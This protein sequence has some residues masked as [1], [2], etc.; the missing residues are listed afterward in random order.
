MAN[1]RATVRALLRP[2]I[3]F[4]LLFIAM[5]LVIA[6]APSAAQDQ[7]NDP[8]GDPQPAAPKWT[9]VEELLASGDPAG[10]MGLPDTPAGHRAAWLLNF[11]NGGLEGIA[12]PWP[13]TFAD[14]VLEQLPLPAV[15][16]WAATKRPGWG[17]LKPLRWL[18]GQ[19]QSGEWVDTVLFV[20]LQ[21]EEDG[22]GWRLSVAV[23]PESPHLIMAWQL[24]PDLS[25]TRERSYDSVAAIRQDLDRTGLDYGLTLLDVTSHNP[26]TNGGAVPVLSLNGDRL[27]NLS[28]G[29]RWVVLAALAE[30]VLEGNLSWEEPVTLLS[31]NYSMPPGD[32]RRVP[33]GEQLPMSTLAISM[34]AGADNTATD[35]LISLVSLTELD[36][37]LSSR[38]ANPDANRPFLTTMQLFRLKVGLSEEPIIAY[39]QASTPAER[40]SVLTELAASNE[41]NPQMYERWVVPQYVKQV[42]WFMSANELASI[43]S[44]LWRR[45]Y[46]PGMEMIGPTLRTGIDSALPDNPHWKAVA[47]RPESE[48]GT[49]ALYALLDHRDGRQFLLTMIA[50]NP[51]ESVNTTMLSPILDGMLNYIGQLNPADYPAASAAS[52]GDAGQ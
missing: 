45:S 5:V 41:V 50:N 15:E 25:G 20:L 36:A 19:D 30:Q 27:L 35:H 2:M 9:D 28:V 21:G 37:F 49:V 52:Q 47:V 40:Q 26:T 7:T 24:D 4:P 32:V 44:E 6:P 1:L 51:V 46:E 10:P 31:P 11:L 33:P 18:E 29:V 42:G 8:A 22:T 43:M 23:E 39:T 3:S 38:I 16:E 12:S 48:P 17:E 34:I 13:R 14:G